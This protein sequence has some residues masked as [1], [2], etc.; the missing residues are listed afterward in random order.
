MSTAIPSM[1]SSKKTRTVYDAIAN[2]VYDARITRFIGLGVQEQPE[3]Q[4]E[5][6]SPAF[7]CSIS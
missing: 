2:D 1:S 5:K 6:K 7:K 4:G 3:W